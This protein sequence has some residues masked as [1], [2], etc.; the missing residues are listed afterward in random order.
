MVIIMD[1]E[2]GSHLHADSGASCEEMQM[3]RQQPQSQSRTAWLAAP[4][5]A[6][7]QCHPQLQL[8]LQEVLP[9]RYTQ[10]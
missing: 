6:L 1:M 9:S 10:R 7:P 5:Q 8:G 4:H 3:P 2:S